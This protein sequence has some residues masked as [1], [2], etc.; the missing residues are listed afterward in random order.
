MVGWPWT[1]ELFCVSS[2]RDS[3]FLHCLEE[4]GDDWR[5]T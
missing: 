2:E 1:A 3:S 4:L 5:V